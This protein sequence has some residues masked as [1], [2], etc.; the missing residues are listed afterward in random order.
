ME[1]N[2]IERDLMGLEEFQKYV[3]HGRDNKITER[4]VTFEGVSKFKSVNRAIRRGH[5]VSN[6]LLIPK[7]PFNNR[8]NTSH[9]KGTHSRVNNELKKYIYGRY[10]QYQ[11]SFAY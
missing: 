9:R 6:G 4:L 8:S 3:S 7:R 1:D 11:R 5:R 10:R 2:K